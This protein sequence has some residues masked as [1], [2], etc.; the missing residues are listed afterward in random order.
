MRRPLTGPTAF[1]AMPVGQQ[2]HGG[3]AVAVAGNELA[4][5][6]GAAAVSQD[7]PSRRLF[8]KTPARH[9]L[10]YFASP[11]ILARRR[12][13]VDTPVIYLGTNRDADDVPWARPFLSTSPT[14]HRRGSGA[15]PVLA[16]GRANASQPFS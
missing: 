4:G 2:D 6:R 8:A 7:R 1:D 3:V 15:R 5:V 14:R 11:K 13:R 16:G 10:P 9:P 12:Y